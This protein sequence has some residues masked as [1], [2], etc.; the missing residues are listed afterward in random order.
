MEREHPDGIDFLIVNAAIADAEHKS[1]IETC[2]L[3][4]LPRPRL[5]SRHAGD[6]TSLLAEC[7]VPPWQVFS[8]FVPPLHVL[9]R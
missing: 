2:A 1:G 5:W 7:D 9:L 4:C 6:R 8:A 3:V